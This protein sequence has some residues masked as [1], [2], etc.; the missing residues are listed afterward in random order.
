MKYTFQL[1]LLFYTHLYFGCV[2]NE[3]VSGEGE[4]T[5]GQLKQRKGQSS[6]LM[7]RHWKGSDSSICEWEA[8]GETEADKIISAMEKESAELLPNL[9]KST[10]QLV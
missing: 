3:T 9:N 6:C 1:K 2:F 5:E 7:E 10:K 8:W 4:G